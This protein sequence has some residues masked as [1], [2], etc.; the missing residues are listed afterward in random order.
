MGRIRPSPLL[1][2]AR[3]AG[4][5]VAAN[6]AVV[7]QSR[8]RCGTCSQPGD[9]R[10]RCSRCH[11]STSRPK[12][13]VEDRWSSTENENGHRTVCTGCIRPQSDELSG[14]STCAGSLC[15]PSRPLA[16]R[17]CPPLPPLPPRR[18]IHLP[19]LI[20]RLLS[21]FPSL[22]LSPCP[23]SPA[24]PCPTTFRCMSQP[25][26]CGVQPSTAT[27]QP[28]YNRSATKVQPQRSCGHCAAA[29]RIRQPAVW[30]DADIAAARSARADL[31]LWLWVMA[32]EEAG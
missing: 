21:P 16:L 24:S 4:R 26:C 28:G 10:P 14:G 9:V 6:E 29:H 13:T 12:R 8:F 20:P 1:C 17:L 18:R 19:L 15:W 27:I 32:G 23:A 31:V 25:T 11:R 2:S 30:Q 3:P 5:R 7:D 22:S